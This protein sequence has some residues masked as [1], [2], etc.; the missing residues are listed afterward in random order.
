MPINIRDASGAIVAIATPDEVIAAIN[1]AVGKATSAALTSPATSTSSATIIGASNRKGVTI[2]NESPSDLLLK[3]G[4]TASATSYT[5]RMKPNEK[6]TITDFI[7][8]I[9]GILES[10]TGVARVTELT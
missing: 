2:Q 9:D 1:A 5:H 8:R 6:M 4:T 7:G 10:D 3:Y